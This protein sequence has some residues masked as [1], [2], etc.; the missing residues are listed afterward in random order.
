[1]HKNKTRQKQIFLG[2]QQCLYPPNVLKSYT[3]EG[4]ISYEHL[5]EP[6]LSTWG[7]SGSIQVWAVGVGHWVCFI[8]EVLLKTFGT[9]E[10]K[11]NKTWSP[12]KNKKII[13][14]PNTKYLKENYNPNTQCLNE[15]QDVYEIF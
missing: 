5:R 14:H 9:L 2:R 10:T 13:C 4:T 3:K 1:M 15:N 8:V 7:P 11:I 6:D 12:L